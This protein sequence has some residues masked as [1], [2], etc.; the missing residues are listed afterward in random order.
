LNAGV[1]AAIVHD[2]RVVLR[3]AQGREGQPSA[4]IFDRRTLQSTPENG[5]RAGYGGATRK[6]G[7]QVHLA[8]ETLGHLLAW[9]VT[10]A[11][12]QGRADVAQLAEPVQAVTGASVGVAF[13]EQGYTGDQPAAAAAAHGMQLGVVELPEAKQGFVPLPRRWVVARSL[14]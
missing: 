6:R 1:F 2:L 12:E 5:P 7:S 10:A 13:V 11:D 14:A 8:V 3:L 9:H 4:A